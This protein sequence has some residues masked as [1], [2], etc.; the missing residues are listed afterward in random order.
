MSITSDINLLK[1]NPL[2]ATLSHEHLRLLAFGTEHLT[3]SKN[4]ILFNENESSDS[5]Y[6]INSGKIKLIQTKNQQQK[7]LGIYGEGHTL[8]ERAIFIETTRPA[9]AIAS[10][11]SDILMIRRV[12][13]R[14]VLEEYPEITLIIRKYLLNKLT[15]FRSGIN[16]IGTHLNEIPHDS[17]VDVEKYLSNLLKNSS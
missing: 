13:I 10:T 9:S 12:L 7:L 11:K 2:F 8:G 3:L 14:R 6:V 1:K 16:Q 17:N 5:G 15:E 4:Q